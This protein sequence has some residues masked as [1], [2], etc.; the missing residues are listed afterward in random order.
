MLIIFIKD[1]TKKN[2]I[3]LIARFSMEIGCCPLKIL[4]LCHYAS[5]YAIKKYMRESRYK[6]YR[7]RPTRL[8]R[9]FLFFRLTSK[10]LCLTE[11][12]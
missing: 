1:N 5:Y 8:S 6:K 4:L 10:T 11:Y 2:V 7:D 9:Y 3:I 12:H